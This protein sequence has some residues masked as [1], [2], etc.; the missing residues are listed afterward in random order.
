A[1]VCDA[2]TALD[3]ALD[4]VDPQPTLV[5]RL[6]RHVRLPRE[7]LPRIEI[8]SIVEVLC[9]GISGREQ[10]ESAGLCGILSIPAQLSSAHGVRA[11]RD[12]LVCGARSNRGE[13][14]QKGGIRHVSG[15]FRSA[16]IP[17]KLSETCNQLSALTTAPSY[18]LR[19][20]ARRT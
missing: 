20:I 10:N 18:K 15:P 2:A 8:N 1:L 19:E 7:R 3:S 16:T 6:V 11:G 12:D 5:E 4:M 14:N 17:Y 9:A 13:P